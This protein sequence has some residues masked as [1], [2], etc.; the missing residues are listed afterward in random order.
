[1]DKEDVRHIHIHIAGNGIL[2]S[3]E[4]RIESCHLPQHR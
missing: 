1:M 4:K 3:H 2:L